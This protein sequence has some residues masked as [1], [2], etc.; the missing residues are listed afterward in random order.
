LEPESSLAILPAGFT[1][2][3]LGVANAGVRYLVD[4]Y[5][6]MELIRQV[7]AMVG[8]LNDVGPILWAG[9]TM[10]DEGAR[11]ATRS[12]HDL[13]LTRR[14][15]DL[16]LHLVGH[17]GQVQERGTLLHAVWASTDYNPN[18]IEV[19]VSTLRQ[20]LEAHG[21]R[22][23]HTVRGIGYVCRVDD[24]DSS[25]QVIVV[26]PPETSVRDRHRPMERRKALAEEAVSLQTVEVPAP[27]T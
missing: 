2:D 22:I 11:M 10:V 26:N 13:Q 21:P 23:L 16:L 18:V 24:A 8:S 4:P 19:T 6:P 9:D 20:K 1:A 17:L 3:R 12:G 7:G 14:E 27:W 5:H 25:D 15:F